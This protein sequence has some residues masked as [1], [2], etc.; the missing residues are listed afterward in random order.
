MRDVEPVEAELDGRAEELL[1]PIGSDGAGREVDDLLDVAK[2]LP[3]RLTLVELRCQRGA[4]PV[5]DE[6]GQPGPPGAHSPSLSGRYRMASGQKMMAK[7]SRVSGA[8]NG[9]DP[10]KTSD[11]RARAIA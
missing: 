10:Q 8:R 4:D 5:P 11:I 9:S 1:E 2:S 6:P 3:L 7:Q